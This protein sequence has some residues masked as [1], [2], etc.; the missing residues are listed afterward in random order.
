MHLHSNG[1]TTKARLEIGFELFP[2]GYE[3]AYRGGIT[4]L[5]NGTDIDIEAGLDGQ[6]LDAYTVVQ[7]P[8]KIISFEPHLH[9]PGERMCL[10]A[11]WGFKAETLACV[12]Y[13]HNWVRTYVFEEAY[14]PLIPTGAI[15]H[16]TGYMNNSETNPNVADPRNWQGA[17]NRS[18]ANMFI[19]LGE[20]VTMTEEQFVEEVRMRV[21]QHGLTKND[22]FIGCPLCLALVETPPPTPTTSAGAP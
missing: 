8:T 2:E 4:S 3:P 7:R 1:R 11:I 15:L 22:Y 21:A 16:I 10:E 12:G 20:R 19:D 6:R 18:V 9:A 17:G 13:D 14:Q 5:A